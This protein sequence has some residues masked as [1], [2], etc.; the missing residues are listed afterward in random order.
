[1]G[2]LIQWLPPRVLK[3][4]VENKVR[5]PD[6]STTLDMTKVDVSVYAGMTSIQ[7]PVTSGKSWTFFA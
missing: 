5:W 1:M 6:V 4:M 2:K 7:N 3:E